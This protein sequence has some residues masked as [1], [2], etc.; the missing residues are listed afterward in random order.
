MLPRSYLS[1]AKNL[2][3]SHDRTTAVVRIG[4]RRARHGP[5]P[6]RFG[7]E[8]S[9]E[10][11]RRRVSRGPIAPHC[12]A[13]CS[14]ARTQIPRR[15]HTKE[16]LPAISRIILVRRTITSVRPTIS[17]PAGRI[18]EGPGFA[19][20][21]GTFRLSRLLRVTH[22]PFPIPFLS[23]FRNLWTTKGPCDPSELRFRT[24]TSP[25]NAAASHRVVFRVIVLCELSALS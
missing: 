10:S 23:R 15:E 19:V 25:G 16:A 9:G 17:L 6:I 5:A 24:A 18:A 21:S 13:S 11:D 22:A 12:S 2:R 8:K 14:E 20:V 4:P 3:G 1:T 7:E